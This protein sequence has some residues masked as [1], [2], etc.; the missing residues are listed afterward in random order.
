MAVAAGLILSACSAPHNGPRGA[1]P[2][3]AH[4]VAENDIEAGRYLAVVGGCH[5]C[6]TPGYLQRQGNVPQAMLLTGAPLGYFGPWGTTYAKNLRLYADSVDEETFVEILRTRKTLP[7]M[8]WVNVNRFSKRD[9][10][11]L[12]A[13]LKSLGPAGVA[14]PENLPPGQTPATPYMNLTPERSRGSPRPPT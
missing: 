1:S 10:R 3:E 7:P 12:Y 4:V 13:Y 6:H 14:A 9:S 8:P 2:G 11:A 5:D